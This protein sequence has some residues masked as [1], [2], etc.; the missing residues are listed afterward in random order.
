LEPSTEAAAKS[1]IVICAETMSSTINEPNDDTMMCCASCGVAEV[2]NIKLKKC[3]ACKSVRYCSVECRKKHRLKRKKSCK[4]RAAELRDEILF[5]QPESS[6]FG[7]CP[8]CLL[9]LSIDPRKSTMQACC[10]KLICLGC[11]SANKIREEEENL[12]HKCPFC[13]HPTPTTQADLNIHLMKRVK[14]NDP[15]ATC[16]MGTRHFH[17]G[18]Y[19]AAIEYWT[20]AAELGYAEAHFQL[21]TM[22]REGR[23]VEKD[24]KKEV[25]HLEEAAINGDPCGRYNL[26]VN[27]IKNGRIERGV[28][29]SI[30]AA[31]LGCNKSVGTLTNCYANGYVSKED[32]AAALRAHQAA[33]DATKSPQREAAEK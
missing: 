25:Y 5:R 29:H 7:D 4:K 2:D 23:G 32:F 17:E 11:D 18:D 20:K 26:A 6:H 13:R 8:I 31:N 14:V 3:T 30:I 19:D 16:F 1:N 9:P 22:Y 21:S 15:L 24:E 12:Q 10:S 28:K 33:V 27:E